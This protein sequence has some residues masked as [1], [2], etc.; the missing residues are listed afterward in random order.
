MNPWIEDDLDKARYQ[1]HQ[2]DT[3]KARSALLVAEVNTLGDAAQCV[4]CNYAHCSCPP[5]TAKPAG[6]TATADQPKPVGE[7][8]INGK[9]HYYYI[10]TL[11][12]GG[13]FL[14]CDADNGYRVF[15]S[16]GRHVYRLTLEE[17]KA[18]VEERCKS[19]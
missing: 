19:K 1:Q 6:E 10:G 12:R 11:R 8:V 16:G 17:A 15:L 9:Y 18:W 14:S 5:T 13:A 4:D 2:R 7:W 3:A